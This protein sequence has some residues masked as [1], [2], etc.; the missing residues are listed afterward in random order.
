MTVDEIS[1]KWGP[2][3]GLA[4][5]PLFERGE[6]ADPTCHSV[7]LDGGQGT[8]AL[9]LGSNQ[10]SFERAAWAWS[11]DIAHHVSV[12]SSSVKIVRWDAPTDVT[13]LERAAVEANLDDFYNFLAA[14]QVSTNRTVVAICLVSSAK[15]VRLRL[16]REYRMCVRAIF[17]SIA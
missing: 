13:T 8:F 10:D 14:D 4:V 12:T 2:R 6:V 3:F 11:S 16:V 1:L 7:F 9:S 5:S 17:F 15:Y